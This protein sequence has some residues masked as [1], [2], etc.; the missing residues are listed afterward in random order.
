MCIAPSLPS[1]APDCARSQ[2]L[3]AADFIHEKSF[4]FM[5]TVNVDNAGAPQL[6]SDGG[7]ILWIVFLGAHILVV[8]GCLYVKHR[9][10]QREHQAHTIVWIGP[11][12]ME[13]ISDQG[14]CT[15]MSSDEISMRQ[16]ICN[17][18]NEFNMSDTIKQPGGPPSKRSPRGLIPHID[19]ISL[20]FW[21]PDEAKKVVAYSAQRAEARCADS[22]VGWVAYIRRLL[23]HG[24]E[25][26]RCALPLCC[27]GLFRGKQFAL[28]AM[29]S[30]MRPV[31]YPH[32]G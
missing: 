3:A 19:I 16:L 5:G 32:L 6:L 25:E 21:R 17:R 20:H 31:C 26:S 9:R 18:I 22:Q 29:G 27:A 24:L 14:D 28:D 23:R 4:V 30:E 15:G 12:E 13:G 7:F 2:W 1:P 11:I 8:A 10:K